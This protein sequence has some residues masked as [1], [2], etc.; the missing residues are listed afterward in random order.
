MNKNMSH[1]IIC[2]YFLDNLHR[3]YYIITGPSFEANACRCERN[4][5]TNLSNNI[6][7]QRNV[8]FVIEYTKGLYPPRNAP[9]RI[10]HSV[11]NKLLVNNCYELRNCVGKL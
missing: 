6:V 11:S 4:R 3:K 5:N 2:I 8:T 10:S 7:I 1:L 9:H